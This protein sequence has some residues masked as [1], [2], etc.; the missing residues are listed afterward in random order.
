M[1][2]LPPHCWENLIWNLFATEFLRAWCSSTENS[3]IAIWVT[4]NK[5]WMR[6]RGICFFYSDVANH[7][8]SKSVSVWV[9]RSKCQ[10]G[11]VATRLP[12]I[13]IFPCFSL[14]YLIS[15]SWWVN[16]INFFFFIFSSIKNYFYKIDR[17]IYFFLILQIY[18]AAVQS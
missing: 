4:H 9:G 5:Y 7:I 13:R 11:G 1:S 14:I 8:Q 12:K 17:E 2:Y 18:I 6:I 3:N 15:L 16:A 10:C